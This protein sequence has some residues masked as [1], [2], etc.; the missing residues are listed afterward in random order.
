MTKPV[1]RAFVDPARCGGGRRT[2]AGPGAGSGDAEAAQRAG[3]R[4]CAVSRVP[5]GAGRRQPD[6]RQPLRGADQRRPD[7][8]GDAEGDRRRRRRRISFET[9]IYDTGTVATQFTEALERAARRG[10]LVQLTIDAVGASSMEKEH[11]E[12]LRA[13]GCTI[14]EFNTPRVVLARGS[15]LPH[16]SQDPRRR[17]RRSASRAA[18]ASPTTGWATR[19]TRSTGATRRSG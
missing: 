4:G 13:A 5:G 1:R 12:R 15:Q 8:P 10:V 17:R 19:R 14:V 9:Y 6:P 18:S 16:P 7:L 3:S 2:R 11:L